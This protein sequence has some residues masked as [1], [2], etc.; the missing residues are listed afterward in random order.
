MEDEEQV[1]D[2]FDSRTDDDKS[3]T[4]Q[5]AIETADSIYETDAFDASYMASEDGSSNLDD[6]GGYGDS[7]VD[8]PLMAFGDD[9]AVAGPHDKQQTD[10]TALQCGVQTV[11]LPSPGSSSNY[12]VLKSGDD[13]N[14]G[15]LF[16]TNVGKCKVFI[17]GTDGGGSPTDSSNPLQLGAG[18]YAFEYIPPTGSTMIVGVTTNDCSAYSALSYDPCTGIV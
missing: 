8:Y 5:S 6:S 18:E 15:I 17:H 3:N 12:V 14:R 13:V 16:I 7:T 4:Y 2:W 1:S 10:R 11:E 9:V